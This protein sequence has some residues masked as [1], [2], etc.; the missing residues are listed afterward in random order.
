VPSIPPILGVTA[1]AAFVLGGISLSIASYTPRRSYATAAIIAAFIVPPIV[2]G[3][4]AE[5]SGGLVTTIAALLDPVDLLD[6][7]NSWFFGRSQ[8]NDTLAAA[9]L[10]RESYVPVLLVY[11]VVSVV[12]TLR[13]YLRIAA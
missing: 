8:G 11:G 12:A 1:I 7:A 10:P 3:I 13:R 5:L 6:G 9:S 4:M 2:A